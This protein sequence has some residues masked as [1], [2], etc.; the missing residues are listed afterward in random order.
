MSQQ[1]DRFL[2]GAVV[3]SGMT[4]QVADRSDADFLL[5]L[6]AGRFRVQGASS[7]ACF[8]PV[9]NANDW[10][11]EFAERE[12]LGR[13]SAPIYAGLSVSDPNIDLNALIHQVRDLGFQGICNFPSNALVSGRIQKLLEDE[14]LGYSRE[15]EMVRSAKAIGL[16]S[17]VY[18]ATNAQAHAMHEAGATTICVNVGFTSGPTGVD[19]ELSIT[20]A[21]RIIDQV[22]D[23]L[24]PSVQTLCAGGPIITPEDAMAVWRTSKVQ[25]YV[26]GSSLDRLP[27]EQT[28]EEVASGFRVISQMSRK[29]LDRD[30]QGTHLIGSSAKTQ[31]LNRD[32]KEL[33]QE[34]APVLIIGETGTGKTKAAHLLHQLSDRKRQRLSIIDCAGL[35][36]DSGRVLLMGA[37]AGTLKAGLPSSR[38]ALEAAAR[39]TVIFDAIDTL[40]P[41]HQGQI[42]RF[43]EDG[44]VQRLGDPDARIV[45]A[46]IIATAHPSLLDDVA[47]H[48]FRPDLYYRLAVHELQLPPLRERIEDL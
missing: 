36:L 1:K 9:R 35:E 8:L 4:A 22:L 25:G 37:T 5:V 41:E 43:A 44:T 26:A 34:E 32:L 47:A 6:N 10:V 12:I 20:S 31:A 42:L 40:R 29:Q 30:N 3:G 38:G 15:I 23:G 28:L 7:L 13:V 48:V 39:G 14:G 27:I 19:S 11:F 45:S 21:A 17:L 24:P 16:D 33:A 46:R 2:F 18:V